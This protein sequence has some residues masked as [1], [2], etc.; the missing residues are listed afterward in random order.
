MYTFDSGAMQPL[1]FAINKVDW[2][3]SPANAEVAAVR[4]AIADP[5][6]VQY[7][8]SKLETTEILAI[9][10]IAATEHKSQSHLMP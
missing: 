4:S 2:S 5:V 9:N 8:V 6:Y 1:C 3:G 10:F 7:G